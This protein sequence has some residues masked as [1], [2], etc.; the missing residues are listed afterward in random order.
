MS[1]ISTSRRV[2]SGAALTAVFLGAGAGLAFA[3]D[4]DN[5]DNSDN[6]AT[7]NSTNVAAAGGDQTSGDSTGGAGA[8]GGDGA[9]SGAATGGDGDGDAVSGDGGDGG[10]GGNGG[11]G[12]NT[13]NTQNVGAAGR[14]AYVGNTTN[15]YN[16]VAADH[17]HKGS[18]CDATCGV[19]VA[20]K[21]AADCPEGYDTHKSSMTSTESA[22]GDNTP[23]GAADTG[24]GVTLASDSS[25]LGGDIALAGGISAAALLGA[26]GVSIARRRSGVRQGA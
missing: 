24:D 19:T 22:S 5:S 16:S 15:N 17:G 3:Q 20:K 1:A 8:A 10:A 12:G 26:Y 21:K 14:D 7:D 25:D 13:G 11:D 2:L 4:V 6:S 18:S 9:A 23:V